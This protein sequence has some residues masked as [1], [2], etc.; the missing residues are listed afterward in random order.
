V[1]IGILSDTH[2]VIHPGV[3]E[4]F[5]GVD[6]LLHAGDLGSESVLERL[7]ALAPIDAVRG[8]VDHW[9][10][11]RRLP[12]SLDLTIGGVRIHMTHVGLPEPEWAAALDAR[13][14]DE[15]PRLVV[16]GHTHVPRKAE[17]GG[18]VFVNPGA[19]G[20]RRFGLPLSI[21]LLET[22]AD[23]SGGFRLRLVELE[24]GAEARS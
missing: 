10:G 13:P 7:A 21:A 6:R 1:R 14:A 18:Y 24:P 8:N 19:A 23:A 16:C 2:E 17:H 11:A 3:F 5:A 20:R 22:D 9:P 15:R 12:E 4:Q